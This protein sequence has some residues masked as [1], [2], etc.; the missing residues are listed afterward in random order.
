MAGQCSRRQ[1]NAAGSALGSPQ[2]DALSPHCPEGRQRRE[3]S[4]R[5]EP[6]HECEERDAMTFASDHQPGVPRNGPEDSRVRS[7]FTG[8]LLGCLGKVVRAVPRLYD[9]LGTAGMSPR[10][11]PPGELGE[12]SRGVG[13]LAMDRDE[14]LVCCFRGTRGIRRIYSI[15]QHQMRESLQILHISKDLRCSLRLPSIFTDDP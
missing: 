15:N 7:P 4:A 5:S 9:N 6:S 12:R 2:L 13:D 1:S 3:G 10:L 14:Q 8:G 11:S